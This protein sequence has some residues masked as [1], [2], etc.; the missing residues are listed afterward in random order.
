MDVRPQVDSGLALSGPETTSQKR[1]SHRIA[2][3]GHDQTGDRK[4]TILTVIRNAQLVF[5]PDEPR[6]S[7]TSV[8]VVRQLGLA[9]VI[10]EGA[11]SLYMQ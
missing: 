1:Q 10:K 4:A 7:I 3:R 2:L 5:S 8:E 6:P 11:P 9:F